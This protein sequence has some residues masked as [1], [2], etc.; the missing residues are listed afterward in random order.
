MLWYNYGLKYVC[1]CDTTSALNT[2]KK[3]LQTFY[4]AFY[5]ALWSNNTAQS[6]AEPVPLFTETRKI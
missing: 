2:E 1:F 4:G 3:R 6:A 5:G